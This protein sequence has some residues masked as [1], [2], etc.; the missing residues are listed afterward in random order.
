MW[1]WPKFDLCLHWLSEVCGYTGTNTEINLLIFLVKV[2][3]SKSLCFLKCSSKEEF[4]FSIAHENSS[5]WTCMH[6]RKFFFF[7]NFEP[8]HGRPVML[9]AQRC[10]RILKVALFQKA[11]MHL[12]FS[13]MCT[14]YYFPG[15]EFW[16][17]DISNGSNHVK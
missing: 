17:C 1:Y 8:F 16:K 7:R 2:I 14:P 15:L 4:T 6:F 10:S 9:R 5:L 13:Q 3:N 12:S 11:L